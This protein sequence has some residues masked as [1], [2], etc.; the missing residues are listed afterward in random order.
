MGWVAD[1]GKKQKSSTRPQSAQSMP[2]EYA[3]GAFLQASMLDQAELAQ[4]VALD[5]CL[6]YQLGSTLPEQSLQAVPR[7]VVNLASQRHLKSRHPMP[8]SHW[9]W[10]MQ[11]AGVCTRGLELTKAL[12]APME[13]VP[14]AESPGSSSSSSSD[15]ELEDSHA[16]LTWR[17]AV[18][19]GQLE[20]YEDSL[21]D[22]LWLRSH[23]K[24][25]RNQVHAKLFQACF[26]MLDQ[27]CLMKKMNSVDGSAGF[28]SSWAQKLGN[29]HLIPTRLHQFQ[30]ASCLEMVQPAPCCIGSASGHP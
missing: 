15:S 5:H 9:C 7:A 8:I 6:Q 26:V 16:A 22:L 30:A 14:A 17:R 29:V 10:C 28:C 2:V 27:A 19:L 4:I 21:Q 11:A 1:P 24:R 13:A 3:F 20:R 12:R 18:A 25:F 23:S